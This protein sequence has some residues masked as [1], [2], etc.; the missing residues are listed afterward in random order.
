MSLLTLSPEST[1]LRRVAKAHAAGE[2]SLH[3]YREARRQVIRKFA[4]IREV[5]EEHINIRPSEWDGIIF[6]D[7]AGTATPV[8]DR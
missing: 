7:F 4:T 6:L 5:S 2:I 8:V 3:E 1:R